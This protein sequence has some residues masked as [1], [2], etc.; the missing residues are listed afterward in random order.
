ML[1][2]SGNLL[3][4]FVFNH[5]SVDLKP[6]F[7][8]ILKC[9]SV[10]DTALLVRKQRVYIQRGFLT[11]VY[12]SKSTRCLWVLLLS[13][14]Q[15]QVVKVEIANSCNATSELNHFAIR[16]NSY[17]LGFWK[18]VFDIMTWDFDFALMRNM[19]FPPHCRFFIWMKA[20]SQSALVSGYYSSRLMLRA[21]L[22]KN[23]FI[24]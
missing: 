22:K 7:A 14:W 20:T 3:C 13:V 5:K 24:S 12:L 16:L 6:S 4:L 10:Y 8:N 1:F 19:Y 2:F 21:K 18:I 9:L 17:F 11:L 15:M 23:T